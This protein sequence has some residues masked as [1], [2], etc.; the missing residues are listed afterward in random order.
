MIRRSFVIVAVALTATAVTGAG[1]FAH[2]HVFVTMKSEL[3]YAPDGTVTGVQHSW[4]FDE[5]F[6]AMAIQG[7]LGPEY[8]N[9]ILV[10]CP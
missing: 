10:T 6:S 9:K 3:V 1:A 4:T 8:A 5:M 2:P 7:L